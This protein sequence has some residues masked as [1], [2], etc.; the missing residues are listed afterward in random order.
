M[1]AEFDSLNQ[2]RSDPLKSTSS[3][4]WEVSLTSFTIPNGE[5]SSGDATDSALFGVSLVL[6][7]MPENIVL[8][9]P[10]T[11]KT[12]LVYQ[13][14]SPEEYSDGVHTPEKKTDG[15]EKEIVYDEHGSAIDVHNFASPISFETPRKPVTSDIVPEE[16]Q[17]DTVRIVKVSSLTP[18][19][20]K[21]LHERSW[22]DR[23]EDPEEPLTIGIALVSRRNV[24]PAMRDTLSRLLHDYSRGPDNNLGG[25]KSN[26]TCRALVDVLG[27]FSYQDVET[28]SLRCILEP[29]LRSASA[30]WAERPISDQKEEFEK[31]ALKQLSNCLTPTPLAL[32]FVTALLEQKIVLSSS[33]RSV[34]HSATSALVSMLRPL[35]W[36]HLLVPLVPSALASDLIQYPAPFILGIP[37]EEKANMDLLNNLP[38]DVTLVD[39]DVGR[40]ILA[41]AFAL[42]NEMV[43]GTE[44]ATLTARALRS[45]VLYL[46]QS[47]GSVFGSCL[48]RDTWCCDSPTFRRDND[49][50]SR[51]FE[52]FRALV[53]SFVQELL[54]GSFAL[55]LF[56][57]ALMLGCN[58]LLTMFIFPPLSLV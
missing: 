14:S 12:Q 24:I 42:D 28:V 38:N 21:R 8:Q 4:G 25:N 49:D 57:L 1:L 33:R 36:S 17:H 39:L 22:V 56:T 30:P 48:S 31:S 37:S 40:V 34:L 51:D 2:N 52:N 53:G 11:T 26:L 29:Y 41:P 15:V 16:S 45:Q 46:A 55:S 35:T 27:N 18:T 19:F 9:E 32:L 6:Q 44:D 3:D 50:P 47:L 7:Q 58:R 10:N 43:R 54:S 20:N 13:N 23:A 5:S